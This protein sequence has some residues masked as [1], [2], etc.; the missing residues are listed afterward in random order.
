VNVWQGAH[1]W[2]V[3]NGSASVHFE[4]LPGEQYLIERQCPWTDAG[5][6]GWYCADAL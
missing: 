6:G 5:G 2:H 1:A 3:A 4:A